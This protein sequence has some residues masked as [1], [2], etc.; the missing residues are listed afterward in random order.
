LTQLIQGILSLV[1][2]SIPLIIAI[3]ALMKS[4]A[5]KTNTSLDIPSLKVLE[6]IRSPISF[7]VWILLCGLCNTSCIAVLSDAGILKREYTRLVRLSGK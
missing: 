6:I 4:L 7:V 2:A 1:T 3:V 5:D